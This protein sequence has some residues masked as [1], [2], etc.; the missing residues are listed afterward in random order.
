MAVC[1]QSQDYQHCSLFCWQGRFHEKNHN[2]NTFEG[3]ETCKAVEEVSEAPEKRIN[4]RS[5]EMQE[6]EGGSIPGVTCCSQIK[7]YGDPE[8][9]EFG[10]RW[11]RLALVRAV[12]LY[13]GSLEP[14]SLVCRQM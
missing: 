13:D 12:C 9:L 3:R 4:H 14:D 2:L 6:P 1:L 7:G 10:L 8:Y 5:E 11:S